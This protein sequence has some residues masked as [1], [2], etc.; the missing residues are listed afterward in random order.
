MA[1]FN[2]ISKDF[3]LIQV[4]PDA[5]QVWVPTSAGTRETYELVAGFPEEWYAGT[6]EKALASDRYNLSY[7]YGG[8]FGFVILYPEDVIVTSTPYTIAG[9]YKDVYPA[10][11]EVEEPAL[12][13]DA[14]GISREAFDDNG[15]VTFKV[16]ANST[17][18]VVGLN[19]IDGGEK[20][21]YTDF[22]HSFIARRGSY[23][24]VEGYAILPVSTPF[25]S[26][27]VFKIE[28]FNGNI[29]Y[30]VNDILVRETVSTTS[31]TMYLDVSL[32]ASGDTVND[33][34]IVND[35]DTDLIA[36]TTL[37]STSTLGQSG[38]ITIDN[39]VIVG[40]TS[41][42]SSSSLDI[43]YTDNLFVQTFDSTSSLSGLPQG[44]NGGTGDGSFEPLT[45]IASEGVYAE[46]QA[47][48]EPL[49]GSAG[50]GTIAVQVAIGQASMLP[51]MAY[52]T[53][54]NG[55]DNIASEQLIPYFE[56]MA[57][58]KAYAEAIGFMEPIDSHSG[59]LF[60]V[61]DGN[62]KILTGIGTQGCG[63]LLTGGRHI[64]TAAHVVDDITAF[65]NI[66]ITFD[67]DEL[68]TVISPSVK[69][70]LVHPDWDREAKHGSDLAIIELTEEVDIL[71][72]RH[73]LYRGSDE[74]SQT[75]TR[76]SYSPR[77]GH[78]TG[79]VSA[80]GWDT[81][82]N[83]FDGTADLMND[84]FAGAISIGDQLI[85]DFDNGLSVNDALGSKYGINGL[86]VA[87]EGTISG[88][89]S[90]SGSLI[91]GKIAGIA[92]WGTT[93][94]TPPDVLEGT[95]STY[96]EIASDTRV[97]IYADWIE[98]NSVGVTVT[99]NLRLPIAEIDSIASISPPNTVSLGGFSTEITAYTGAYFS[100]SNLTLSINAQATV[101]VIARASI[102]LPI[103]D[104]S[105]SVIAG[106][107]VSAEVNYTLTKTITAYTGAI[108]NITG[109]K[110][111][112]DN[113]SLSGS[114]LNANLRPPDI[115]IVSTVTFG[116]S[117]N[118][119]GIRLPHI[120]TIH[121][122]ANLAGFDTYIRAKSGREC[123]VL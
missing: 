50:Y 123:E 12:G 3:L 110:T 33:A 36:L 49:T 68:V 82:N 104:I 83:R 40:S 102:R 79:G 51:V 13:W 65:N 111:Y 76:T 15:T 90:G 29:R 58:D 114:V 115:G 21:D 34:T 120:K 6:I 98:A 62:A 84:V 122:I 88:G 75:F 44:V 96:G 52:A 81:I 47:S 8:G 101:S 113:S 100:S 19:A 17:G 43:S 37:A 55:Q 1:T 80:A 39:N 60:P 25:T 78:T 46:G 119:A 16:D 105:S 87:N 97:S 112:F 41:F 30:S 2:S 5:V 94:G 56:S 48:F 121:G 54:L 38:N 35:A 74:V 28:R 64:L 70:I 103:T 85:Y 71:I 18:V 45:S 67:T 32:Y 61:R 91:G 116:N 86:G 57:A 118:V 20:V 63:I 9:Y 72:R 92:S 69:G 108:A 77:V 109:F 89:D 26:T 42:D 14:A 4:Q 59:E 73:D 31:E 53:G 27:D 66:D 95:N 23:S 10:P 24:I 99:A 11:Y 22:H 93:L 7:N 106:I 117:A 107:T